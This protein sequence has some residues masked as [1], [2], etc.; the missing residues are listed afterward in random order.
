MNST[1]QRCLS[2]FLTDIY[3]ISQSEA[4]RQHYSYILHHFFAD[5]KPPEHYTRE[6][7]LLFLDQRLQQR[8][9]AGLPVSIST[10][11]QRMAAISSF[12]RFAAGYT[13]T[14][15]DGKPMPLF[16][17]VNPI[18][19]L[20]Y[21]KRPYTYSAFTHEELDRFFAA[22]PADTVKGL[23][24]R[25][26]FL[27]YFWTARRREEIARL[28]WGDIDRGVIVDEQG[29]RRECWRY[30]FTSKGR[31]TEQQ[32]AELPEPAKA[33]I[34]RY[35]IAAGRMRAISANDAIFLPLPSPRGGGSQ[36]KHPGKHLSGNSIAV[37]F[38]AYAQAAGLD[39]DRLHVHSFRHTSA[40]V[41][42]AA[43]QDILS[44]KEL[45]QHESLDTTYR[46]IRKLNGIADP[47]A[48]LLTAQYAHL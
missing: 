37:M 48:Q 14:G 7:V 2:A 9:H 24:D 17:G 26:I 43:G 47:T 28:R 18:F 38:K 36:S 22:I 13:V 16:T 33:A 25:A 3:S 6:D 15:A 23:R 10:K 34:D 8:H 42:Y 4:T 40:Q 35:L 1:W 44:L 41:R 19:G 20:R 39:A 45:L 11:N 29:K 27:T 31:S 30:R 32:L 5:G 21:G 12:Y 46:Y